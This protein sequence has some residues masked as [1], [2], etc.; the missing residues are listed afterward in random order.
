[1]KSVYGMLWLIDKLFNMTMV[2]VCILVK[3]K[4]VFKQENTRETEV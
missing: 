4:Q 3:N 2:C 1:M